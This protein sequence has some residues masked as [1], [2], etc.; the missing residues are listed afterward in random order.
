MRSFVP[1]A[2]AALA[3]PAAA[4]AQVARPCVSEAESVAVMAYVLPALVTKLGD[5]CAPT[6]GDDAFL[7]REAGR[8]A[9]DL[10]E[11]S[12]RAWPVARVAAER[13][14]KREIPAGGIAGSIA[15]SAVAPVAAE[16]IAAAFDVKDCRVADRLLADLAPLPPRRLASVMALFMELGV[17][18]NDKVPFRVCPA[19][20][21]TGTRARR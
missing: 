13:I 9:R 19:P 4:T 6:L 16:Q 20:A 17:A 18:D 1:A 7:P 14:G 3:L 21:A 12:T 5:K 11:E 8:L 15:R 2:L 10:R